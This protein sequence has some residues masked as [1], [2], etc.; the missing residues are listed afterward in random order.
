MIRP[1]VTERFLLNQ[2]SSEATADD[3]A[4]A[5]DL[6]DTLRAHR[7][8]CIGLAANMIFARKRIICILD[9][10][11]RPLTM[12]NPTIVE[13]S[14]PYDTKEGCLSLPGERPTKRYHTIRV[15]YQDTRMKWHERTLTGSVAQACQHECDH[16]EGILI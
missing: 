11:E 10:K 5:Q 2:P 12:L 15:R 3:L 6:E 13:K 4:I 16:L 14:G 1:I 9:E 7:D 8:T